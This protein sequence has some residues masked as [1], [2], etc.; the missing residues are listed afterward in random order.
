M[1]PL[2]ASVWP[3]AAPPK[4]LFRRRILDLRQSRE[5]IPC[6]DYYGG[7]LDALYDVLTEMSGPI[8]IVFLNFREFTHQLPG[9]G[10]VVEHLCAD[11]QAEN[12]ELVIVLK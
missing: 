8:E 4:R 1:S 7:N 5:T 6:P 10:E 11:V 9:F 12:P 2:Y 3:S